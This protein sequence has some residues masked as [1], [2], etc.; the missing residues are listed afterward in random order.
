MN[1]S[2]IDKDAD[3]DFEIIRVRRD[4]NMTSTSRF[5]AALTVHDMIDLW[6][7]NNAAET[8]LSLFHVVEFLIIPISTTLTLAQQQRNQRAVTTTSK[9]LRATL[10]LLYL[11][12]NELDIFIHSEINTRTLRSEDTSLI[13]K[14]SSEQDTRLSWSWILLHYHSLHQRTIV[15]LLR[16]HYWLTR[17]EVLIVCLER[18]STRNPWHYLIPRNFGG[19]LARWSGAFE[20]FINFIYVRFYHNISGKS[21]SMWKN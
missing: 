12:M 3:N 21:M 8:T 15:I 18:I 7:I 9:A 17:E 19:R 16:R 6:A 5:H 10:G 14:S 4:H 1:D 2:F 13:F 20:W 11:C